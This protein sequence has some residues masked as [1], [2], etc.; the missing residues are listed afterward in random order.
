MEI[1]VEKKWLTPVN[2]KL[3]EKKSADKHYKFRAMVLVWDKA[4][5]NEWSIVSRN[6]ARYNRK[7]TVKAYQE[8]IKKNNGI[9]VMYNH[10][11]EGDLAKQLGLITS[12]T[13]TDSGLIV[14]GKL[15]KNSDIVKDEI[16]EGFLNNISLQVDA[17]SEKVDEDGK[18]VT[19]ARPTDVYETSF[20]P[21]PGIPGAN[22]MDLALA[23]AFKMEEKRLK[24]VEDNK[25]S[26]VDEVEV[27]EQK[28][29]EDDEELLEALWK[30]VRGLKEAN[31]ISN[32]EK[33]G[34][35]DD[36]EIELESKDDDEIEL[37]ESFAEDITTSTAGG[38]I[39]KALKGN[40]KTNNKDLKEIS[41][42][43]I[44]KINDKINFNNEQ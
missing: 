21:I 33:D 8:A 11:M 23:E 44:K 36:S 19:Y 37:E 39:G 14:E 10:Y 26:K 6:G 29:L 42:E 22:L 15:N 35:V 27:K 7:D 24:E 13:D 20:V 18:E 25:D 1:F 32:I 16:A 43:E 2:I 38:A 40:D 28:A 41:D 34:T 30:E 5:N 4:K 9:P 31:V 3:F 12:V 17:K